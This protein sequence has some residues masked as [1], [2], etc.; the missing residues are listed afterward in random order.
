MFVFVSLSCCVRLKK[1]FE[2]G[3]EEEGIRQDR[4]QDNRQTDRQQQHNN[5]KLTLP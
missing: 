1:E 3:E 2:K 5:P 4:T